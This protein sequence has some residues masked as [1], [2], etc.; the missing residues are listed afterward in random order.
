MPVR[1]VQSVSTSL[2]H[3]TTSPSS[4][5]LQEVSPVLCDHTFAMNMQDTVQ[6]S[7]ILSLKTLPQDHLNPQTLANNWGI[8]IET[9]K[10]TIKVTMQRGV[11]TVLH[12]T[13]SRRFCTND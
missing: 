2:S 11:H 13:L 6:V 9:A 7:S 3:D 10:R 1:Q 5:L 8:G 4:L 12:P